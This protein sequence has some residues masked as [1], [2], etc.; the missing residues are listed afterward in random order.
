MAAAAFSPFLKK[1][2]GSKRI[3]RGGLELGLWMGL[4]APLQAQPAPALYCG[5]YGLACSKSVHV[6]TVFRVLGK[7][8]GYVP[9]F[10]Q[11]N[12]WPC[13]ASALGPGTLC[14]ER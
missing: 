12:A 11:S 10:L 1:A 5:L 9:K 13:L 6:L 14:A 8:S 7:I 3:W 2:L 4:G